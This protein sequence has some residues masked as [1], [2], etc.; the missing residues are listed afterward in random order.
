MAYSKYVFKSETQKKNLAKTTVDQKL[1][2]HRTEISERDLFA[3]GMGVESSKRSA[4]LRLWS[5]YPEET[6]CVSLSNTH[7]GHNPSFL[8]SVDLSSSSLGLTSSRWST[9]V[10]V[11]MSLLE[12][13]SK[14]VRDCW[15]VIVR[16][17]V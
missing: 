1:V 5:F 17:I 4:V 13:M 6:P 14:M 11:G 7:P 16:A 9:S 8:T 12:R 3:V 10:T 2:H 15:H